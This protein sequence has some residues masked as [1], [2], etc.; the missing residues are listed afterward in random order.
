MQRPHTVL[1]T[2]LI[3]L[4]AGVGQVVQAQESEPGSSVAGEEAP[5]VD[6]ELSEGDADASE[7]GDPALTPSEGVEEIVIT[8][9]Q[10]APTF[11]DQSTSVTSFDAADIE[12]QNFAD[13]RDVSAYTPNLEI[14]SGFAAS[15]PTLFIRGVGLNDINPNSNSAVAVYTDDVYMNSPSGQ[16]GQLFDLAAIEVLR[17]P[18]GGAYGRNASAGAIHVISRKPAGEYAGRLIA[19]YGNFNAL[20]IQGALET[21]IVSD[22]LSWR[23][24][25]RFNRR[26]GITENRCGGFDVPQPPDTPPCMGRFSPVVLIP[27]GLEEDVNARKNWAARTLVLLQPL[28]RLEM[29][30]LLNLHGGQNK[31]DALQFQ[32]VGTRPTYGGQDRTAYRDRDED[33]FAGDYNRTG[34]EELDLFGASLKGTWSVG[35]TNFTSIT[36]YEWN[37]R[38]IDENTDANPQVNIESLLQNSSYQVSQDL[39]MGGFLADELEWDVGV[40]GLWEELDVDN[41]FTIAPQLLFNQQF[42]QKT[43]AFAAYAHGVW[44]LLEDVSVDAAVRFNF[45]KKQFDLQAFRGSPTSGNRVPEAQGSEGD[46][47]AEPTG[48]LAISWT[49]VPDFT[50]YGKYSHGFKSGHFNGGAVLER[51]EVVPVAPETV[52]AFEIGFKSIFWDDR[53]S[54]DLSAFFYSYD[55]LQVFKLENSADSGLPVQQLINANDA[56]NYGAELAFSARP[57]DGV[58]GGLNLEFLENLDIRINAGWLEGEYLDF[59]DTIFLRV[60]NDQ[61]PTPGNPRPPRV[62]LVEETLDFSGN[63]LVNSPRFSAAG[64][65]EWALP[66]GSGGRYGTLAP[67]YDF[68]WK[69]DVFFD[70]TEGRGVDP[71]LKF[72]ELALGQPAL[73]LHNFRLAWRSP[74]QRVE[75]AAWVQNFT[76]EEYRLNAFDIAQF[77]GEVIYVIGDPR[78]YGGT[79]TVE[80]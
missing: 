41:D 38:L 58:L 4:V 18:Q 12:A 39:R 33:L 40:Y 53:V 20:E 59:Q 72:P 42:Q 61:T 6:G 3:A 1:A 63:R 13:I 11:E 25:F 17:G 56:R 37:D 68:S 7:L 23:G 22:L 2:G 51:Q 21:P 10:A 30:W 64:T 14:K 75:V 26:D 49:V 48:E 71:T 69:D 54:L 52:D 27:A 31:G 79:V 32:H 60:P 16:L 57:L 24:S 46:T 77:F 62:V 70:P 78:T 28:D 73:L 55:N 9:E 47:W 19:T 74:N 44:D 5:G 15:N 36:A 66:L 80:F 67:R 76:N 43:L 65:V 35:E 29:E 45:E 34:Q 8:G 50:I